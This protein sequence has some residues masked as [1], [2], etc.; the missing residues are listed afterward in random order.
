MEHVM[1]QHLNVDSWKC[2]VH[3]LVF[4][5]RCCF[6]RHKVEMHRHP[7]LP[8]N[9]VHPEPKEV[10]YVIPQW[11]RENYYDAINFI[12]KWVHHSGEGDSAF[13]N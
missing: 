5:H 3:D 8:P 12:A 1:F 6:L 7:D 10:K 2:R 13:K 9:M 11:S 4:Q